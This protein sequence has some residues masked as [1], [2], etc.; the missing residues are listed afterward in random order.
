MVWLVLLV[1]VIGLA[2]L[3]MQFSQMLD[4][5]SDE[6]C[7][8]YEADVSEAFNDGIDQGLLK[9]QEI[10]YDSGFTAGCEHGNRVSRLD[11]SNLALDF[12]CDHEIDCDEVSG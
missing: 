9:G 12:S 7:E 11:A 2:N 5:D 10:G 8:D 1:A 4:E 3:M 6:C